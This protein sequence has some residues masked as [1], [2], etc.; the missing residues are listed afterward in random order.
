MWNL[1]VSISVMGIFINPF[2]RG[3]GMRMGVSA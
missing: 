2:P 3:S 1:M